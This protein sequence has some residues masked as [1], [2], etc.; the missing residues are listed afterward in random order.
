MRHTRTLVAATTVALALV[1][2][3]ACSAAKQAAGGVVAGAG[4]AVQTVADAMSLTTKATQQYT[5]VRMQLNE[6]MTAEGT[7]VTV[8][9]NGQTSWKPAAVNLTMMMPKT[10]TTPAGAVHMLLSGTTMYMGYSGSAPAA[11]KGKHWMKLDFSQDPALASVYNQ[12]NGQDPATQVALFT[13][14][15]DIK[16]VGPET[17]DGVAT[18][19]YS[20]TA[21]MAKL[22]TAENPQL[23]SLASKMAGSGIGTVNLDFWVNAQNLPVRM[24][25]STPASSSVA[26]TATVDYSDYSTAPVTVTPPPASDTVDMSSLLNGAGLGSGSSS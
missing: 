8:T 1:G 2:V 12:S 10:A 6:H 19:H 23:K 26:L 11:F 5:S 20:G 13:S 17:V 21:D 3:S 7:S 18:T 16:R 14:S 24:V 4:Q 9:A 25:E 22:A 15:P